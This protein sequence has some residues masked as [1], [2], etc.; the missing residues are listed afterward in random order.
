M[1][2]SGSDDSCI[3]PADF[4]L[5]SL[6]EDST[7][8]SVAK[9]CCPLCLSRQKSFHCTVCVR[10]GDFV[11]STSPIS[12]RFAEKQ[13]RLLEV[14]KRRQFI[15]D[16]CEKRLSKKKEVDT[17]KNEINA[18]RDRIQLLRSL[19]SASKDSIR[20]SQSLEQ[21]M[22]DDNR[23]RS[24]SVLP[25]CAERVK[26]L[27]DMVV[28]SKSNIKRKETAVN[29]L[30]EKLKKVIRNNVPQ[31][32]RFIFPITV[33]APTRS[34]EDCDDTVSALAD[35]TRT[36]YI[37]G[38]WVFTDSTGELQHCIVAPTL[39]GSGNYS[40]YNDWVA[41]TKDGVPASDTA[42]RNPGYNISAALTYTAQLINVLS[43]YLDV[44]LPC[45]LKYSD[46]CGTELSE[47]KFAKRV[48]RLN[49]NV[50]HLCFSQNVSP[51]ILQ[52]NHTL[53]NI[54]HLLNTQVSDLGR[55]GPLYI[56]P[57]LA[58]SVEDQLQRDLAQ[59][60]ED[61]DSC[62]EDE[63]DALIHKEWEN[64][65]LSAG[66]QEIPQGSASLLSQQMSSQQGTSMAG[67]LVT[68]IAS[69]WRGLTGNR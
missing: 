13:L 35:A 12:E 15:V 59:A 45:Q 56:D 33:V 60:S 58:M 34:M 52:P 17:V 63:S 32:V 69:Y 67:G 57:M 41:S 20:E 50:L 25:I 62:S 22:K 37:R 23:S 8:E 26:K 49:W 61:V 48:A 11:L 55:Q 7:D 28:N 14:R 10:N 18:C 16:E 5:S 44:P 42:E 43:F 40:A 9:E 31:L 54:L 6:I 30:Q 38:R 36:T 21:K 65:P 29:E 3:A 51:D 1:A 68:S 66:C 39:P 46:F 2:T 27:A 19:L 4:N 53:S 24:Q 47:Q 64:I